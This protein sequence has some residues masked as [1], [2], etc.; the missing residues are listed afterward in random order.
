MHLEFHGAIRT[1]TGSC[2]LLQV[3]QERMLIDCG[4][5]QGSPR[6]E[7]RNR[8]PF[9]FDPRS[10]TAVII[11]HAHID[12]IGLL[13]KLVREGYDG[14]IHATEA[15]GDLARILLP[16]AA[17][18]NQYDTEQR[19]RK[20]ARAGR[21]P[22]TPLYLQAD[23]E[24]ALAQIVA[25]K[26]DEETAIGRGLQ[27]RFRDAGHILGSAFLEARAVEDRVVR[28]LTFSG[29]IGNLDQA[30]IKDPTPPE[31]TEVL[32]IESTYGDREHR[33][34]SDT[35][36]ELAEILQTA[37]QDGGNVVIPAFA[38][39]RTQEILY[40]LRELSVEGRLPPF[41]VYVDSPLAIS[42][43]RIVEENPQ[44]YDEETVYELTGLGR[45]PLDV[46]NLHFTRSAQESQQINFVRKPCLII[47]AS[48]MCSAGRILHHLKHNLWKRE[49]HVIFTG[50]QGE[51]TLGRLL[52][53]GAPLV[54]IM[55]EEIKAAA[56]LHTI[57]GLSAHADR[58]GLL[59]WMAPLTPKRPRT[60]VVH[61]EEKAALAF[62]QSI[63][64]TYGFA[65]Q[66]PRLHERV[67]L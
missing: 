43:T 28:R 48:G 66:A 1:V 14:P 62:A 6:L 58:R 42:A 18:I 7:A 16:D 36:Q 65:A 50:F 37:Y 10:L 44:C 30:I 3:G 38:V 57:G 20:A 22:E 23:A 52:V 21:P 47:S 64:E 41:E 54:R 25:H 61:G 63:A 67:E 15:T 9:S 4:L 34:R 19:N 33:P 46:P 55:G 59:D 8:E 51:G 35:L 27:V 60:F 53:D 11:T 29:D 49:A 24:K 56:H 5:Y 12:H 40:R 39:G 32:L 2:Y 45:D 26:Y 13:P 31:P 17:H